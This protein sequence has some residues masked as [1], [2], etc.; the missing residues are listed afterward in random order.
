[1]SDLRPQVRTVLQ[2][3][4][5]QHQD[6]HTASDILRVLQEEAAL[7]KETQ[8]VRDALTSDP[9]EHF[10]SLKSTKSMRRFQELLQVTC[11]DRVRV[12]ATVARTHAVVA[13]PTKKNYMELTFLYERR[14]RSGIPP[15]ENGEVGCQVSYTIE[16]SYD[17][18]QRQRLLE[19]VVWAASN[20][21]SHEPAVCIQN[22]LEEEE[23]GWEDIDDDEAETD[24]A[25]TAEKIEKET[26]KDAT[27]T[28]IS[29]SSSSS[30]SPPNVS[31]ANKKQKTEDKVGQENDKDPR[32]TTIETKDQY[33]AFLD[34]DVLESFLDSAGLSPMEDA[35]AFFL[36]MT[37][38]FFEHEW[39]LVGYVLDQFFGGGDSDDE[40]ENDDNSASS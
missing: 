4:V 31:P 28:T 26:T 33:V 5:A 34:P 27:T 35:T 40:G 17:H 12:G 24:G 16:L 14:P 13:W 22:E 36:L 32:D 20:V 9:Y 21:P 30:A 7:L 38:P 15:G 8:D 2:N 3:F 18:G 11:C 6:H 1:M 23:G 19:V 25:G 37:F 39:D 10:E 29:S